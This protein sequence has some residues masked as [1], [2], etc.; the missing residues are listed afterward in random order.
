[1]IRINAGKVRVGSRYI[2]LAPKGMPDI[3]AIGKYRTYWVE[4]KK[5]G[6]KLR[7]DQEKMI[8]LLRDRGHEVVVATCIDD[9]PLPI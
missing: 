7:P 8:Q 4:T 6:E 9:L 1:M 2:R 3:Q 5:P